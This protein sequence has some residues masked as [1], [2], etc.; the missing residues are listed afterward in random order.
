MNL[1]AETVWVEWISS[2]KKAYEVKHNGF[3][4]WI[5][6]KIAI[7]ALDK[8]KKVKVFSYQLEELKDKC[9]KDREA[10]RA[11]N[12]AVSAL[13]EKEPVTDPGSGGPQDPPQ[14]NCDIISF[15]KAETQKPVSGIKHG[16]EDRTDPKLK[17]WH[18]FHQMYGKEVALEAWDAC[19]HYVQQQYGKR[20][21]RDHIFQEFNRRHSF[22]LDKGVKYED[23]FRRPDGTFDAI[24]ALRDEQK[25]RGISQDSSILK[26]MDD[27]I[28][29]RKPISHSKGFEEVE[30]DPHFIAQ[31]DKNAESLKDFDEGKTP[32]KSPVDDLL[33]T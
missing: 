3:T 32:K 4:L 12:Q 33:D 20:A 23:L 28:G 30:D 16:P 25:R 15:H 14:G 5:P 6:K 10:W 13:P 9:R 17:Y 2:R 22:Y 7:L 11:N 27:V 31:R 19:S 18:L 29:H 21:T 1:K 26:S 8:K 24:A